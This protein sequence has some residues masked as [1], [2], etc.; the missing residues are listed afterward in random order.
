M[1]EETH[2]K[3]ISER[4]RLRRIELKFSQEYMAERLILRLRKIPIRK[5]KGISKVFH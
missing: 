3:L 1:G 5:V 4:I 2:Y